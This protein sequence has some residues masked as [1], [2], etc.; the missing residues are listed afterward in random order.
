MS[1]RASRCVAVKFVSE[2]TAN[3]ME[4]L[5]RTVKMLWRATRGQPLV[6]NPWWP[7]VCW[8]QTPVLNIRLQKNNMENLIAYFKYAIY[9]AFCVK[10]LRKRDVLELVALM[11]FS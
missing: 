9:T 11:T 3:A 2:T 6:V 1:F 4:N 5:A 7:A 8:M 10:L